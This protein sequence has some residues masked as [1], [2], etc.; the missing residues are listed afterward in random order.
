LPS[1]NNILPVCLTTKFQTKLDEEIQLADK[2][3]LKVYSMA[4]VQQKT[5]R[6]VHSNITQSYRL[7]RL[8]AANIT[9]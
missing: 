3:I 2:S 9:N 4:L 7:H 1:S 6:G 8:Q 5:K